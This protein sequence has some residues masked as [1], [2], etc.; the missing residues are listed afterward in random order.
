M[1]AG[2]PAQSGGTGA[3]MTGLG[4]CGVPCSFEKAGSQAPRPAQAVPL[5]ARSTASFGSRFR[6]TP[7]VRSHLQTK[8][9]G[10]P[11]TQ[12][13][14]ITSFAV[15]GRIPWRLQISVPAPVRSNHP[16]CAH[17]P[18]EFPGGPDS[19]RRGAGRPLCLSVRIIPWGK[20]LFNAPAR[21][22]LQSV[23]KTCIMKNG[24]LH[25]ACLWQS[26]VIG[27]LGPNL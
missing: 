14:R 17:S 6:P 24:P 15:H 19:R 7:S 3:V 20:A 9:A 27:G 12:A 2:G 18:P 4:G 8:P 26:E 16:T 22:A 25:H 23:V 13:G 21:P 5:P 11:P 10:C 1:R